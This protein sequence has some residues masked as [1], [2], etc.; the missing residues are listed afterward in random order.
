MSEITPQYH[1]VQ[2]VTEESLIQYL[3][4]QGLAKDLTPQEK[5]TFLSI[6]K[7]HNLNPFKREIYVTKYGTNC[8]IVTGFEVYLKR[9]ERTGKLDGFHVETSGSVSNGDLSATITIFRKDWKN[10][11]KH[12]VYYTEYVQR[13]KDGSINKF[14]REKPI[15][16]IKKVA[17]AQGFR[18]C[19]SDELGGL[20]YTPDEVNTIDTTY[21]EVKVEVP[22]KESEKERLLKAIGKAV[23]LES[24]EK[25]EQYAKQY[26]C[27]DEYMEKLNIL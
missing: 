13:T 24:L 6:A 23:D 14:W 20:P 27:L 15:T 18:L 8:S 21:T 3:D 11:F 19:F 2:T 1:A 16:M 17:M 4:F 12:Q 10:A 5:G 9:A 7:A 22:K 26:N 25:L